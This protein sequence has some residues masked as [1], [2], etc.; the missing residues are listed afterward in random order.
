MKKCSYIQQIH[1]PFHIISGEIFT[2][3]AFNSQGRKG[4]KFPRNDIP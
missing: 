1:A 4:Q 3:L 2:R